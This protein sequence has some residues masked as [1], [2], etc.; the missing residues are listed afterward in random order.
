MK[1]PIYTLPGNHEY[2]SGGVGYYQLHLPFTAVAGFTLIALPCGPTR[3]PGT[4]TSWT[5]S[6][7]SP[8]CFPTTSCFPPR[9]RSITTGGGTPYLNDNLFATFEPYFESIAGWIWGHEHNLAAYVNN[10]FG[11]SAGRLIGASSYEETQAENPYAVVYPE[12]PYLP[13]GPQL[14]VRDSYMNHTFAMIAVTAGQM[15]SITYYEFPSWGDYDSPQNPQPTPLFSETFAQPAPYANQLWTL[16]TDGGRSKNVV[17]LL[18]AFGV[19][20]ANSVSNS[21]N[22]GKSLP[23]L[24]KL[25]PI[26]GEQMSIMIGWMSPVQGEMRFGTFQDRLLL[27]SNGALLNWD[28]NLVG[29]WQVTIP[30]SAGVVNIV[31]DSERIYTACNGF[32]TS[33]DPATGQ[34]LHCL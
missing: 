19:L 31:A 5:T 12:V 9:R 25:N 13:G 11:L 18:P 32:V 30:N 14:H 27:G 23:F 34:V 21:A 1:I 3:S 22:N 29:L 28:Q 16:Q 2:Y 10:A 17:N 6:R 8:C 33:F 24:Y 7:A 4:R 20:Y 26:T 15:P